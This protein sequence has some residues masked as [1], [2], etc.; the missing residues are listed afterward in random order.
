MSGVHTVDSD[1]DVDLG[2]LVSSIADNW[3]RILLTA[4]AVAALALAVAW[5]L[6][7]K[8]KAETRILIET[9]ESIYT[10]P[11]GAR[12]DERPI[13][14]QEGVASQVE[15]I[16]SA[17]LLKQVAAKLDLASRA[18]FDESVGMSAV[19]RLLVLTGLKNDPGEIPAEERVLK[20]LRKKLTVAHVDN[21][22]VIVIEFSSNDRRLAAAVPRAIAEAYVNLQRDAKLQS[23]SDA[24]E[25]L[26]QEID[27]LRARV[28]EAEAKVASFRAESDIFVGEDDA[29][30]AT[31]QLAEL[32]TELS[33]VR[34]S[35]SS[36]Q[37]KAIAVERALENGASIDSIPDVLDSQLIQRLRERQVELKADIADLSTTLL[38]NHPRIK[39]LRSQLA[40]LDGQIAA[41]ARKLLRSLKTEAETARIR[42]RELVAD[43]NKLK[44]ESARAGE[45]QVELRALEREAAAQREL[46]ESYLTRYREAAARRDRNYLPADARVFQEATV[47][48]EP[49]FPKF[50]PIG[51][52]AFAATV[53]VMVLSLLMRELFS[54]RAMRRREVAYVPTRAVEMPALRAA[55][56]QAEPANEPSVSEP[57]ARLEP[58][59][60]VAQAED[61]AADKVSV[62]M[63]ADRLIAEGATRAILVSPEGD[64]AAASAVLIAREIADSGL[65]VLLMDL[66]A[67]GVAAR[68]MLNGAML[69]GITNL[70]ASEAQFTDVIHSDLYSECDVIPS[71]TANPARAMRAIERLP[72]IMNSLT[73]AYDIVIVE[74][75]PADVEGV[76]RLVAPGSEV[77][78]SA[79][80]PSNKAVREAADALRAGGYDDLLLV[81][82]VGHEP[83]HSPVGDRTAA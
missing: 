20:T 57:V 3:L 55:A 83:P 7:P 72:I 6:P 46:L 65:R 71:G 40:D 31:Q 17:D 19:G 42:E 67:N 26:E 63:V 29:P 1:I 39:A 23:N 79:L 21:S 56:Q 37:A 28:R 69:P 5:M 81:S 27:D 18:E 58:G 78:I 77:L 13:L 51:V 76:R 73:T 25:W 80:E 48:A 45:E 8:Y 15:L 64:E 38:G 74:C 9:R 47:P 68:P 66:T 11:D 53:L 4:L 24:T 43:V 10:R 32:S 12:D 60:P 36:A 70:L 59:E 35:R 2:T 61:A 34:A 33:R 22:R 62:Q 30:L 52:S 44:A 49:Y 75:G 41:E 16:T 54:G 50:I 14:D 82:P